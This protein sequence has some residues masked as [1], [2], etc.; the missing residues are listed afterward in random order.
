M[1]F[2]AAANARLQRARSDKRLR[3]GMP[4]DERL[5]VIGD[6]AGN[7]WTGS[8]D[9]V[10]VRLAADPILPTA[11]DPVVIAR[12]LALIEYV[13]GDIRPVQWMNDSPASLLKIVDRV[14]NPCLYGSAWPHGTK[15]VFVM[16]GHWADG[17][18]YTV[19][20]AGPRIQAVSRLFIVN[21]DGSG[22]HVAPLLDVD[23]GGPVPSETYPLVSPAEI[24]GRV[25]A[26]S[27]YYTLDG[28]WSSTSIV[29]SPDASIGTR[30][31]RVRDQVHWASTNG[32]TKQVQLMMADVN[33]VATQIGSFPFSNIFTSN[34]P[35]S[36][37]SVPFDAD[38]IYGYHMLGSNYLGTTFRVD[39]STGGAVVSEENYAGGLTVGT[40]WCSDLLSPV[41]LATGPFRVR[42]QRRTNAGGW[43]P[44][45]T[46]PAV[47][48][49][50]IETNA[51]T[52]QHE[53]LALDDGTLFILLPS[54]FDRVG[55]LIIYNPYTDTAISP[56]TFPAWEE[57]GPSGSGGV[58][59][60]PHP[61]GSGTD[62]THYYLLVIS[63][64]DAYGP[65]SGGILPDDC[66]Y[67]LK[68]AKDGTYQRIMSGS[69][70][71][72]AWGDQQAIGPDLVSSN[73]TSRILA[74]F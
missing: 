39:L 43:G 42:F 56:L 66:P 20:G 8:G 73:N 74:G 52:L 47:D 21:T 9:H 14:S 27:R 58:M 18:V 16:F 72:M 70:L 36:S 13:E 12:N 57:G 55:Q 2:D 41:Y 69:Q 51:I 22:V 61:G 54:D 45:F 11:D 24:G 40:Q 1:T 32:V 48:A 53:V 7:I 19:S 26:T 5:A 29:P 3:T 37:G 28:G 60:T 46:I 65:T 71:P 23:M 35:L 44:H 63:N 30:Y 62:G 34:Y 4:R 15:L 10:W 33:N 49:L 38:G 68:I 59:E 64:L 6:G 25:Y 17:P 67:I 50:V 31:I